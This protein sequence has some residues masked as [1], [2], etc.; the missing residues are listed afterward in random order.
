MA[1][2]EEDNGLEGQEGPVVRDNRRIDP[3]TFEA[4]SV[5]DPSAQD[6]AAA[7]AAEEGS[8]AQPETEPEAQEIEDL[9][10]QLA[11]RTA[12][13]QRIQAEYANY[14]K[15]VDRDRVANRDQATAQVLAELLPILDDIGRAREHDE[16]TGAFRSVGERLE[17]ITTKLGLKRFGEQGDAFDPTVHDALTM[18]PAPGVDVPTVI[19]VYEP[20]YQMGERVL[21]PARVVVGGPAE[22]GGDAQAQPDSAEEAAVVEEAVVVEDAAQEEPQPAGDG[23]QPGPQDAPA[24]DNGSPPGTGGN[25]GPGQ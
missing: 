4:R 10:L 7:Q 5:D 14:R 17:A 2:P 12:D 25:G 16:L 8:D 19:E 21:R 1:L 3:E 22:D 18:V 13:L 23:S 9:R 24:S 6:T 15:R 20:G 11:E